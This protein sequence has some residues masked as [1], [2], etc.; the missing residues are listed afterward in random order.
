MPSV[1]PY[2]EKVEF[3]VWNANLAV[4]KRAC[5]VVVDGVRWGMAVRCGAGVWRLVCARGR[6]RKASV[7]TRE[8]RSTVARLVFA[9]R[10]RER[11]KGEKR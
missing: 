7:P 8:L 3:I 6:T 9:E 10:K 4:P 5:E 1:V 2:P 11:A